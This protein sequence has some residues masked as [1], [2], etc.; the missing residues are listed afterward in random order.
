[1]KKILFLCVLLILC[2]T[3]VNAKNVKVESLSFVNNESKTNNISAKVLYDT[4]LTDTITLKKDAIIDGEVIEIIEP[5]RGKRNGYLIIQPTSYS[6]GD[7][8][9]KIVNKKIRA[10]VKYYQ[11]IDY[12]KV[13]IETGVDVGASFV[14]GGKYIVHFI[15][16]VI[17]PN[18]GETRMKSG[19][20]NLYQNSFI[21]FIGKGKD[22]N[23]KPKDELIYKFYKCK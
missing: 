17:S 13:A 3:S 6:E 15:E 21:S 20:E 2:A 7:K 4:K 11:E 5:K 18:E 9:T 1:M 23:I 14:K 16:G 22:I 12:K 10:K 19:F 8:T